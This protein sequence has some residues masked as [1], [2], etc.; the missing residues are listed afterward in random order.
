MGCGRIALTMLFPIFM[1]HRIHKLLVLV[2]LSAGCS[3]PKPPKEQPQLS[4]NETAGETT[5]SWRLGHY[6]IRFAAGP[7][8]PFSEGGLKGFSTYEVFYEQEGQVT[9][10]EVASSAMNIETLVYSPILKLTDYIG[11]WASPSERWLLI[12][13]DVPNDCC[14]CANFVLIERF[15]EELKVSYLQMPTWQPPVK[16]IKG[17]GMPPIWHEDPEISRVSE[18]EIEFH[19]SDKKPQR[20]KIR[21]APKKEGVT[22]P[23]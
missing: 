14:P 23:G 3:T 15:E 22:F 1:I 13:E 11:V 9:L 17:G 7:V 5:H 8:R 19:F 20:I 10:T 2:I 16:P 6:K 12:K 18:D 4:G 21:D